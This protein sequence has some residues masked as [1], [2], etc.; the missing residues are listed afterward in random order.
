MGYDQDAVWIESELDPHERPE[1]SEVAGK[2]EGDGA[3]GV[4][5][6]GV[7]LDVPVGKNAP[8]VH[9]TRRD[10]ET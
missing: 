5:A 3:R 2:A 7:Q 9:I 4:N 1:D 8:R 6:I 10:L